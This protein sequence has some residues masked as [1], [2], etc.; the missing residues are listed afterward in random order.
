MLSQ[1]VPDALRGDPSVATRHRAKHSGAANAPRPQSRLGFPQAGYDIV[2]SHGAIPSNRRAKLQIALLLRMKMPALAGRAPLAGTN[3]RAYFLSGM[4]PQERLHLEL[5]LLQARLPD[6]AARPL[7]RVRKPGAV[8]VRA[9]LSLVLIAGGFLGFLPILGF[10]MI[11]LGLAL[12]ALDVPFLRA[13]LA[14]FLGWINRKLG[15]A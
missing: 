4:T 5:D 6:W 14:K 12:I 10:W 1:R 15:P 9:P 7:E 8:W 2:A 11:P 3:P 13:P